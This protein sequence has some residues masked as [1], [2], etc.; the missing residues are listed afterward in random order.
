[1]FTKTLW[2]VRDDVRQ[3]IKLTGR[4]DIIEVTAK[5][6]KYFDDTVCPQWYKTTT[7]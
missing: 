3:S 2:K 1:M 6:K 7:R 5:Y 4:R